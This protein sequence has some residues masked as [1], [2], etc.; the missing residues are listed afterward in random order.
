MADESRSSHVDFERW[1]REESEYL[2]RKADPPPGNFVALA[3]VGRVEAK[4][5]TGD[6]C[7]LESIFG[8]DGGAGGTIMRPEIV[9]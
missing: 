2:E 5:G 8:T 6:V 9:M 4:E 3:Y 1:H 7:G